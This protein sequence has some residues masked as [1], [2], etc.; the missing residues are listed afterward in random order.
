MTPTILGSMQNAVKGDLAALGGDGLR[1]NWLPCSDRNDFVGFNSSGQ[2]GFTACS[3][4][5]PAFTTQ[6]GGTIPSNYNDS[7]LFFRA[8][9]TNNTT[10]TL[11]LQ[12]EMIWNVECIM[13]AASDQSYPGK[14]VSGSAAAVTSVVQN[15]E[16]DGAKII[17]S[18]L[19]VPG[20]SEK[21]GRSGVPD[22]TAN[23]VALVEAVTGALTGG[24]D[25]MVGKLV[26]GGFDFLSG[27]T[28]NQHKTAVWSGY[29]E[30]SP[31][32]KSVHLNHA[33][34]ARG[35]R[36]VPWILAGEQEPTMPEWLDWFE[37]E[38]RY[39]DAA[40]KQDKLGLSF[41][42]AYREFLDEDRKQNS[43]EHSIA[44]VSGD[45]GWQTTVLRAPTSTPA[46]FSGD[47]ATVGPSGGA[48][49]FKPAGDGA[50]A[51]SVTFSETAAGLGDKRA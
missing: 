1:F 19:E 22:G 51:R 32:F 15:L 30:L 6:T 34:H 21:M 8:L 24:E 14:V 23:P 50:K 40:R 41:L 12:F 5:N 17:G 37:K 3:W 13:L 49:A 26:K 29:P 20:M 44:E 42:T 38:R 2:L 7:T 11:S 45:G 31:V 36:R 27:L 4:K 25:G 10:T 28:M 9:V 18:Q 48:R 16:S 39:V 46:D 47:H 43:P 35:A 33:V